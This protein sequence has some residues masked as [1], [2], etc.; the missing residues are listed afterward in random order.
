VFSWLIA[1]A[2][3]GLALKRV[4]RPGIAANLAVLN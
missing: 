3:M 4:D 1:E 2:L